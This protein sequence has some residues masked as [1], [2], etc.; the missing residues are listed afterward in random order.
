[1]RKFLYL[2]ILVMVNLVVIILT[3]VAMVMAYKEISK[4]GFIAGEILFALCIPS[5]IYILLVYSKYYPGKEIP[6][7]VIT[8]Y[9]MAQAAGWVSG[10]VIFLVMV[11][12]IQSVAV[13][14]SNGMVA[15]CM[16]GIVSLLTIVQLLA[17]NRLIKI[18][19]HNA[20]LNLENSF[21]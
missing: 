1:M 9:R 17:G 12:L 2:R 13:G 5:G 6:D 16:C 7:V 18:I 15:I 10:P 14:E 4:V 20:R 19:R 3:L 21:T 8:G 11:T